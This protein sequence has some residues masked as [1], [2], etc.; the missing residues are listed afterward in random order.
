MVSPT[1]FITA[2]E[3]S[4]SVKEVAEKTGL[5]VTSVQARASTY[6]S[7]HGILL[8]KMPR[9]NNGGFNKEAAIKI[10]EQVRSENVVVN[11]QNK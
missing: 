6:R 11:A 5:K 7:K 4:N 10:L 9:I 2:W 1:D 8:K 3:N